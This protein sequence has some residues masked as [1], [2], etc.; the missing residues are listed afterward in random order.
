MP[1]NDKGILIEFPLPT[2]TMPC[3]VSNGP[4]DTNGDVEEMVMGAPDPGQVP[5][6]LL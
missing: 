1:S 6:C 5:S 2:E 3:V 4:K